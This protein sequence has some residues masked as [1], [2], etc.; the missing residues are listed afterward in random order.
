MEVYQ[1]RRQSFE[2]YRNDC[3]VQ[4]IY[5]DQIVCLKIFAEQHWRLF[6]CFSTTFA[7]LLQAR[8]CYEEKKKIN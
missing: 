6:Q 1:I 2:Y 8:F 4:I 7:A 3:L 5:F